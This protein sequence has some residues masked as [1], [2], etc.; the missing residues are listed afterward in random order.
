MNVLRYGGGAGMG[1]YVLVYKDGA[2]M[3]ID[4]ARVRASFYN[5][6]ELYLS[7]YDNRN[8]IMVIE[9]EA[10]KSPEGLK[11]V[12]R[13]FQHNK[14]YYI[15]QAD[16]D[17]LI[18]A[19]G[20]GINSSYKSLKEIAKYLYEIEYDTI[21]YKYAEEYFLT[22]NPDFRPAACSSVRNGDFYGRNLDW[23]YDNSVDFVVRVQAYA[24]RYASMGVAGTVPGLDQKLVNDRE[25][26]E[27]YKILPF[28]MLDGINDQGVFI[29]TNVVPNDKGANRLVKPLIEEKD[30]LCVTMVPRYV[31]DHFDS[32]LGAIEYLRDYVAIYM[33][34]RLEAIGYECHYM[35]GDKASGKTYV[36]EFVNNQLVYYECDQMTNF[37]VDGVN[38]LEDGKV[39]TPADII[40]SEEGERSNLPSSLGITR[41]G[42]GLE[43][44]NLIIENYASANTKAGMRALMN[45]LMYTKSYEGA[46]VVSDPYWFSEFVG[47]NL[48]VDNIPAEFAAIV[49]RAAEEYA[50]RDR[51][52]PEDQPRTWQTIHSCVYDLSNKNLYVV[53]QEATYP[54]YQEYVFTF[55]APEATE[56]AVDLA[57]EIS[58]RQTAVN[59]LQAQIDE[60]KMDG[61]DVE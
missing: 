39:Y 49:A 17:R 10:E 58:D 15:N 23:F 20:T 38:F 60:L 40:V 18:E 1:S 51:D 55:I 27:L 50:R 12:G 9:L 29:N 14:M 24:G 48:T 7:I 57:K 6:E 22:K 53:S 35:I 30:R 16:G 28:F 54:N 4:W 44:W 8:Q 42:S 59:E 36:V 21:D 25:Y 32:A 3:P 11:L 56:V 37:Y 47:G 34:N 33:T 46:P 43:R 61:G 31:L 45:D 5:A 41:H 2:M 52:I 13:D 26:S 19:D